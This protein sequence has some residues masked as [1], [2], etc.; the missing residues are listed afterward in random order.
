MSENA[1]N[2]ILTDIINEIITPKKPLDNGDAFHN[3]TNMRLME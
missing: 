2:Q 1:E 3:Q